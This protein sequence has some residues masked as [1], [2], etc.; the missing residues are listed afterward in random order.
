MNQLSVFRASSGSVP[1]FYRQLSS[2]FQIEFKQLEDLAYERPGQYTVFDI[3]LRESSQI[4]SIKEWLRTKPDGAKVI[5]FVDKDSR[6]QDT[7]A[8]AIGATDVLHRPIAGRRLLA[9]LWSEASSLSIGPTNVDIQSSPA[10]STAVETLQ[11]IFI[12]ACGGEPLDSSA[13]QTA[14]DAVVG[15][16]ETQGLTAWID[17]V[18]TYHSQTYQHCLLV[19]G[20][21]VAFGQYLGFSRVDRQRLSLAGMLHDIGKARIPLAILEKPGPLD[22]AERAVVSKHPQY[23]FDALATMPNLAPEMLDMVLHHHE[24][25]DGS[26]YPHRLQASEIS[27]L[28][29]LITIADVFGA[30]IE[31]RSYR[32][33]LSY[34][35]AYQILLD[36]GPKLDR[37]LVRAFRFVAQL[38]V[39]PTRQ[40]ARV[41]EQLPQARSFA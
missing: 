8:Y 17:T 16:V 15:Q 20:L 3:D 40:P 1:L 41:E 37:D 35:A 24:Y 9:K 33:P 32:A 39:D 21:A 5:F 23:G 30:L 25:L 4:A 13:V 29:R 38:Q 10:V 28:V 11:N 31:R 12:A 26:G 19:T 14:S 6:I 27:D 34:D 2:I 36:M 22:E 7:R 18:R